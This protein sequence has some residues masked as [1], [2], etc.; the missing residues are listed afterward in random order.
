MKYLR[1]DV[2]EGK[3]VC[4]CTKL[5]KSDENNL[6]VINFRKKIQKLQ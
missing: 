1:N 2:A 3:K 6:L 5:W 4:L